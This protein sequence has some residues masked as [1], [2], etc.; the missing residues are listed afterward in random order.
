MCVDAGV[1]I[2][3]CL[4]LKSSVV[5]RRLKHYLLAQ[6]ARTSPGGESY[7]KKK[8]ATIFLEDEKGQIVNEMNIRTV[9]KA[10]LGKPLRIGVEHQYQLQHSTELQSLQCVSAWIHVIMCMCM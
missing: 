10:M 7:R 6:K 2:T 8:C 5:L 4:C 1:C 9:S 3:S